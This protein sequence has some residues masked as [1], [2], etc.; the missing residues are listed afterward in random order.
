MPTTPSHPSLVWPRS[1]G[2]PSRWPQVSAPNDTDWYFQEVPETDGR[3]VYYEQKTAEAVCRHLGLDVDV[4]KQ[5]MP[6]P[7]GYKLYAHRKRQGDGSLR[8]DYYVYGSTRAPRFRSTREF[9]QHAIWLF[10]TSIPLEEHEKCGCPYSKSKKSSRQSMPATFKRSRLSAAASMSPAPSASKRP[11]RSLGA[12]EPRH[13]NTPRKRTQRQLTQQM[14]DLDDDI[15]DPEGPEIPP[16]VPDRAN[17][18]LSGQRFRRGELIWFKCGPFT[19]PAGTD[20]QGVGPIGLWPGLVSSYDHRAH[21]LSTTSRNG[22]MTQ[23][24]LHYIEYHIRPLGCLDPKT[25]VRRDAKDLMPWLGGTGLFE[26]GLDQY[27]LI[28]DQAMAALRRGANAAAEQILSTGAKIRSEFEQMIKLLPGWGDKWGKP[29]KFEE[30]EDWDVIV[31][32]LAYGIRLASSIASC[33]TQTDKITPLE[34]DPDLTEE[35]HIA[36]KNHELF[37]YQGL[38][39]GGERIWLEDMVRIKKSRAELFSESHMLK[40]SNGSDSRC[41]TLLIRKICVVPKLELSAEGKREYRCIVYGDLFELE[42][43]ESKSDVEELVTGTGEEG[44][45]QKP[46]VEAYT[47]PKGFRY[48]KLNP[49]DSEI[50]T[51]VCDVA[52]RM[53]PDLLDY[54]TQNWLIDPLNP[55]VSKGRQTP[56]DHHWSLM[57]LRPGLATASKSTIWKKDL[58]DV[59]F[60][61]P[62]TT[63]EEMTKYYERLVRDR[64]ELDQ[65]EV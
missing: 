2:D 58:A 46:V 53:Y 54:D 36:V 57:G 59:V 26:G 60:F 55:E 52:G 38:Y 50:M 19:A 39:L 33:W 42:E 21:T 62:R 45:G 9:E 31:M 30:L 48:R 10:D 44:M 22:D 27:D 43:L 56:D 4:T 65:L 5:R 47:P 24:I 32:R 64:L 6:L 7:D 14:S 12:I 34:D 23:V 40:G 51:D 15:E 13:H 18:L 37:L 41:M 8:T 20:T 11:R 49:D 35:D 29:L 25:E 61:A 16:T 1:D 28:G 17:E 3:W 63:W